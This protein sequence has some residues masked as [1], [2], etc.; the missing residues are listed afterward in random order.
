MG[1]ALSRI[2]NDLVRLPSGVSPR[3]A[4]VRHF[5]IGPLHNCL[6]KSVSEPTWVGQVKSDTE[7]ELLR[8]QEDSLGRFLG[9]GVYKPLTHRW[10]GVIRLIVF[11]RPEKT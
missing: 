9:R 6:E 5:E 4:K 10:R 11:L 3:E 1:L 7:S 8:S 2:A